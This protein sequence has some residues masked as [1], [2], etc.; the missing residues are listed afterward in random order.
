MK[1]AAFILASSSPRRINMLKE[2]GYRFKVVK[3]DCD[4]IA[5]HIR[6]ARLSARHNSRIKGLHVGKLCNEAV[7]LSADTVVVLNNRI[8]GKPKNAKDA[9]RMLKKLN[10]RAH[11]V[12]TAYTVLTKKNG[13]INIVEEKIVE[14]KVRFGNFSDEDYI[15]YVKTK[16]PM[17]KA[18]AYAVQGLGSRFVKEVKGSYSNVVGLPLFEVMN[19]LKKAGVKALWK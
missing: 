2:Q 16:E 9:L 18:G 13:K 5:C 1:K 6:G 4:E 12:L 19:S 8:L 14:S 11:S 17:D 3:P 7:I 15:A 10:N